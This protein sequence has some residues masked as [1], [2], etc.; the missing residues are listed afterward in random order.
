MAWASKDFNR[1]ET[2]AVK[3]ADL[4]ALVSGFAAN[5][6]GAGADAAADNFQTLMGV[7]EYGFRKEQDKGSLYI[8]LQHC[9]GAVRDVVRAA[10]P[11]ASEVKIKCDHMEL[12][13]VSYCQLREAALQMAGAEN[14]KGHWILDQTLANDG[15]GHASDD[16]KYQATL[17]RAAADSFDSFFEQYPVKLA[18]HDVIDFYS[19]RLPQQKLNA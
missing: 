9:L 19:E 5:D 12:L 11:E 14:G 10:P 2:I 7:V 13:N 1:S 6:N 4:A 18:S 8:A 3:R 17:L 16:R 15:A